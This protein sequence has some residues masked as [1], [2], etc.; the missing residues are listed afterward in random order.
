MKPYVLHITCHGDYAQKLNGLKDE[1][2][3][4]LI[5]EQDDGEGKKTRADDLLN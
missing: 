4:I 1:K 2:E 5:F 3:G